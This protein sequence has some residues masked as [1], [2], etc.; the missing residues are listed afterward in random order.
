MASSL[1]YAISSHMLAAACNLE[2]FIIRRNIEE[3]ALRLASPSLPGGA[4]ERERGF[5]ARAKPCQT[6]AHTHVVDHEGRRTLDY[7][8]GQTLSTIQQYRYKVV[9]WVASVVKP[10][11]DA[12]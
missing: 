8:L 6:L 7:V 1:R 12:I 10:S 9:L 11:S 4:V 2:P 3:F 5:S